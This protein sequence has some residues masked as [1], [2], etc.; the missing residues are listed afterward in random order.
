MI[1]RKEESWEKHDT[2]AASAHAPIRQAL[3]SSRAAATSRVSECGRDQ[4]PPPPP[5]LIAC[6][7]MYQE[8]EEEQE[9]EE[10]LRF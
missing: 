8:G 9:Q 1:D 10:S 2:C 7:S 3:K 6:R 4:P 5:P